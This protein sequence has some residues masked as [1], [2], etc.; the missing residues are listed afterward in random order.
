MFT[1]LGKLHIV[2]CETKLE[3]AK[4]LK[5]W[6]LLLR[7]NGTQKWQR[8]AMQLVWYTVTW[9][10]IVGIMHLHLH[11]TNSWQVPV[12]FLVLTT[13]DIMIVSQQ[14]E[15]KSLEEGCLPNLCHGTNYMSW[16]KGSDPSIPNDSVDRL[17]G[18]RWTG[19]SSTVSM[20]QRPWFPSLCALV[21]FPLIQFLKSKR[22][23]G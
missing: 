3:L 13:A 1:P 6:H 12:N 22:N 9:G 17:A 18:L 19:L 2:R 20:H 10:H 5:R 8:M 11:F 23:C 7:D 14:M 16:F 4:A 15:M 21:D